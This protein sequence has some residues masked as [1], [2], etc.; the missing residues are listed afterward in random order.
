M[1]TSAKRIEFGLLPTNVPNK[2]L[3]CRINYDA[4]GLCYATYAQKTRGYYVS[5][6]PVTIEVTPTH[7]TRQMTMFS[8]V[9][10]FLEPASRFNAKKMM[11][12][13]DGIMHR[14]EFLRC[15]D[16][17]LAKHPDLVLIVDQPARA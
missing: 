9:G 10:A 1:A 12:L 6:T 4:G 13:L 3:E 16:A 11:T 14:E 8:G 17:V 2:F 5:V 15:R 7:T